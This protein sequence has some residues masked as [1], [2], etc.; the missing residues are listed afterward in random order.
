MPSKT[1]LSGIRLRLYEI[2]FESD[3][4]AGRRYD[5][6]LLFCIVAS[7]AVVSLESVSNSQLYLDKWLFSAEWFFTAIFTVDYVLRIWIVQN[8]RRYIFRFFGI[9]DLLSILPTYL[10]LFFVGAQ[11]LMVIRS[12]RL[13]R[14]FRIFKLTRYVGEGQ[15]LARALKSSRHKII[16]FLVTI[17]TSV[18]ITGTLMFLIEGPSHGFTS[19]PKSIYW[20]IVTMTT[21]GYG[22]IAPQ[23]ALGQTLASFIMIL[24]YGIIAVPTGIVSAEMVFQKHKETITTQVCPHCLKEGH[25]ADAIYCKFCGGSLNG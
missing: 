22:D 19:I 10:G 16:V 2:V 4:P 23:T 21:V 25:D 3:T 20:A 13:L 1:Q 14:I 12:I 17:L 9:I 18:I 24:G 11:S 6:V 15:N 5:V 7:V 8:K